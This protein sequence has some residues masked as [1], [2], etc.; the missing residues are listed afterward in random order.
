MMV[1]K[2]YAE[3]LFELADSEREEIL[4]ELKNIS[5]YYKNNS[6]FKDTFN[7]PRIKKETKLDIIKEISKNEKFINF[8]NL[9][10]KENRF[11]II[12]NIYRDYLKMV[13]ELKKKATIKI[14]SACDLKE[15]EITKIVEKY[16]KQIGLLEADVEVSIDESL[17]GGLKLIIDGKVYDGSLQT[18]L[19]SML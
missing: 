8:I 18:K 5:F 11:N 15:D 12:D 14:I 13:N 2:R 10:L 6:L 9:L 1:S 3:A 4:E 16:K 17:I 7:N 19:D